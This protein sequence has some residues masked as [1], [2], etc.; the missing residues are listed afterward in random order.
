MRR[1]AARALVNTGTD[2]DA[3]LALYAAAGFARRSDE[4]LVLEIERPT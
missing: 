4:L 2:N 3:A 1:G